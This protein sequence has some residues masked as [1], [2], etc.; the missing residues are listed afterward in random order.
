VHQFLKKEWRLNLNRSS[1]L[2]IAVW[3]V[4]AH[5]I[6][7]VLPAIA[8]T[9]SLQLIGICSRNQKVLDMQSKSYCC[10]AWSD[11]RVMLA[12]SN[13]DVVYLATPTALHCIH[14]QQILSAGKH[15]WCEKPLAT[16][17]PDAHK[18]CQD[19]YAKGLSL[20]VVCGPLFHPQF[21]VLQTQISQ[22]VIGIPT[23]ITASFHFPHL[24]ADNFRY[25]PDL[26]GGALLDNG[27]Y[28]LTVVD[29]LVPGKLLKLKCVIKTASGYRVDTSAKAELHFHNGLIAQISW[30]YGGSYL[31]I[32]SIMGSDGQLIAAPF[33]SKPKNLPPY[34]QL[35]NFNG[36]NQGIDFKNKNMFSEMLAVFSDRIKTPDG[37]NQ[38][39]TDALR[40]QKL[41][42]AA[43]RASKSCGFLEFEV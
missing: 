39:I 5:A 2:K 33:F 20:A 13:V 40:S 23:K 3:G 28:L 10:L 12:D 1:L 15:L 8:G 18:L 16:T 42:D 37:R 30:G 6:R 27:F 17:L 24:G 22:G 7:S 32:I 9:A 14:G 26:G 29:A 35:T 11:P 34:I 25:N 36:S 38:L 4:G 41:L 31:N 43:Y 21:T 19:A